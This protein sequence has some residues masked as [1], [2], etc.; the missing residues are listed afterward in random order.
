MGDEKSVIVVAGATGDVGR[1][2][3]YQLLGMGSDTRVRGLSRK[4]HDRNCSI[5]FRP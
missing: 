1:Q 3:I 5:S 4:S 2:V